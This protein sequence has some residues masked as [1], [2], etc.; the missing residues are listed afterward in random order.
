M[1]L[2]RR[3]HQPWV[4]R[5]LRTKW[6]WMTFSRSGDPVNSGAGRGPSAAWPPPSV[7]PKQ[8]PVWRQVRLRCFHLFFHLIPYNDPAKL[9]YIPYF[10]FIVVFWINVHFKIL[11]RNI[12]ILTTEVF[13]CPLKF[14]PW[15]I[16]LNH[17]LLVPAGSEGKITLSSLQDS[18]VRPGGGSVQP[19]AGC[20]APCRLLGV[21]AAPAPS[22][23][24]SGDRSC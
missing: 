15:G 4:C 22:S 24:D 14:C 16:C 2:G 23:V 10:L 9:A 18:R 5:S 6:C 13:W 17:R 1:S 12:C 21:P 8:R 3:Q 19:Q 11:H 7:L 20:G